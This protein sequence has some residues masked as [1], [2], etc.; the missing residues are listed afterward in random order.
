M[1]DPCAVRV[2]NPSCV[3]K[4]DSGSEKGLIDISADGNTEITNTEI[5][6]KKNVGKVTTQQLVCVCVCVCVCVSS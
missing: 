2:T 3:C 5:N 6:N 1:V 4:G